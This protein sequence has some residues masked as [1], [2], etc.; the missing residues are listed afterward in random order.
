LWDAGIAHCAHL[1]AVRALVEAYLGKEGIG[2]PVAG[3]PAIALLDL[4]I[5]GGLPRCQHALGGSE[6]QLQLRPG[7]EPHAV[8]VG[9]GDA[10]LAHALLQ[11][12]AVAGFRR[13]ELAN[14]LGAAGVALRLGQRR[15]GHPSF[16]LAQ[17]GLQQP[18]RD[19]ILR[20]HNSSLSRARC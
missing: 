10:E 11:P 7:G 19:R 17:P 8:R 12:S 14:D 6:A 2:L 3:G 13:R 9:D 5:L 18:A 4:G 15:V 20:I 1:S 16:R